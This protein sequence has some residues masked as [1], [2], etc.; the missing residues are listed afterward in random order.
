MA[1]L[2]CKRFAIPYP[3]GGFVYVE[4][5]HSLIEVDHRSKGQTESTAAAHAATEETPEIEGDALL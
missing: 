2:T 5:T 3:R 1:P 4:T